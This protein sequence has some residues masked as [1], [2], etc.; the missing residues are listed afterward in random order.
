MSLFSGSLFVGGLD[1][2]NDNNDFVCPF[3]QEINL[4]AYILILRIPVVL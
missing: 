3:E 2:T 1:D 4:L